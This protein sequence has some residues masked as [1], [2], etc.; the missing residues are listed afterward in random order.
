MADGKC[1]G[2]DDRVGM[3]GNGHGQRAA[4]MV[5]TAPAPS[6]RLAGLFVER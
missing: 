5:L 1:D 6:R 3:P 4:A 2:L